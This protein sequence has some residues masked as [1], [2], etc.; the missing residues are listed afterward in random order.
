MGA[1]GEPSTDGGTLFLAGMEELWVVD[2]EAETVERI[3]RPE[4]GAGDPPHLIARVGDRL[5]MWAYDVRAIPL[6]DPST[7]AEMLAR[8]GWIFIP[9]ADPNRIWVGYLDRSTG[10]ARGLRELREIDANGN[11]VT[12]GVVPPDGAWPYAEVAGGLLFQT[13]KPTLWDPETGRTLRVYGLEEL[14]DMGDVSGDVLASCPGECGNLLFTDL[15]T[16]KQRSV[17]APAG[18]KYAVWTGEFSPDGET[19]AVPVLARE[20]GWRA[21][22]E[23]AQ[24]LALVSVA[25]GTVS[26]VDGST[27]APGYVFTAWSASGD[28]VFLTGGGPE[29]AREVVSYQLGTE[30]VDH[31]DLDLDVGAFYDVAVG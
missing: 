11:A 2:V 30:T 6:D 16:G 19:Y 21:F 28:H 17:P 18:L 8:D 14:G 29:T 26:I 1:S 27:V 20:G 22:S 12:R 25:D 9:A 15:A 23:N 24:R 5:A 10:G 7:D 31:L 13:P 4:L 3:E